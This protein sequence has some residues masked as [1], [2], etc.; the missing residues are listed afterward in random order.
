M[1]D[2]THWNEMYK[3]PLQEIPWEIERAPSELLELLEDGRLKRC[4][5]LDMGCGSG[6]YSIFLA[7]KGFRVTAVDFSGKALELAAARAKEAGL[8]I[9]FI[10]SDA[11]EVSKK[12]PKKFG[13]ILD[14]SLLHHLPF[15]ETEKYALQEAEL[16][17]PGG[18]ILL[19]CYSEMDEDAKGKRMR[20]GKFGNEMYYRTEQEIRNAFVAAG[21]K[22]IFYKPA[23][24][25][26]R[27]QHAA[28]C[29]LF[30]KP[31]Q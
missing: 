14:Y 19:V 26:K 5:A 9:D 23:T 25:G 4:P 17:M 21:L 20:T 11:M 30:E 31:I 3:K 1:A 15:E 16:L 12:T 2:A 27:S 8:T 29:F 22:E 13:F 6:N 18:K 7:H 10:K 24:L 28:H